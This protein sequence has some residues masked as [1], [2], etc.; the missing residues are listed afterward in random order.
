MQ[1]TDGMKNALNE[2]VTSLSIDQH[3]EWL[4]EPSKFYE[5]QQPAEER[6]TVLIYLLWEKGRIVVTSRGAQ[7]YE[8]INACQRVEDVAVEHSRMFG[9]LPKCV[10]SSLDAFDVITESQ[11]NGVPEPEMVTA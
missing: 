3:I 4:L 9:S 8:F 7:L 2:L 5:Q 11:L 1:L 6:L 10:L